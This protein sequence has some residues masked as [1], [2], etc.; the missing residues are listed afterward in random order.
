VV[1]LCARVEERATDADGGI[2]PA[3]TDGVWLLADGRAE[4]VGQ[5]PD[6]LRRRVAEHGGELVASHASQG[7]I[8]KKA[9]GE[10]VRDASDQSLCGAFTV[11]VDHIAVRVDVDREQR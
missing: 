5:A 11:P 6:E 8:R 10:Y 9:L 3:G 1:C 2:N 4:P 7:L